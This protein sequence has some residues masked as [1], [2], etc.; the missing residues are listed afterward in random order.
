M[1]YRGWNERHISGPWDASRCGRGGLSIDAQSGNYRPRLIA[2]FRASAERLSSIVQDVR[3]CVGGRQTLA[4]NDSMKHGFE[5]RQVKAGFAR[6][7]WLAWAR[8]EQTTTGRKMLRKSRELKQLLGWR[9]VKTNPVVLA[10]LGLPFITNWRVLGRV[11]FRRCACFQINCTVWAEH[12]HCG[13]LAYKY[14]FE[15]ADVSS[16][17]SGN[18]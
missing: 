11:I 5:S 2:D 10:L 7:V 14:I 18:Y 12:G 6:D 4:A 15:W 13:L 16:L 9:S 17:S 3:V 1:I 8:C